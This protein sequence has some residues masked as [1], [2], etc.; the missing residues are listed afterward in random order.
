MKIYNTSEYTLFYQST[1]TN[2]GNLH[3]LKWNPVESHQLL[4]A[5]QNRLNIFDSERK[6]II[7]TLGSSG[8]EHLADCTWKNNDIII[9]RHRQQ[10]LI[11]DKRINR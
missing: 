5:H 6:T 3:Q 7:L 9:G 11:W 10:I 8:K 2:Y 4:L 1:F